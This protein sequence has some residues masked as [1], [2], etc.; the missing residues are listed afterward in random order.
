MDLNTT[1][2]GLAL[3]SPLIGSASPLWDDLALAREAEAA[4]LS[5]LVLRSWFTD[6]TGG[7]GQ[8]AAA[9]DAYLGHLRAAKRALGVPV[10][11]S[12]N[13]TAPDDWT[14]PAKRM[15]DAGAD[16]IE[17]N[18][19]YIPV[20]LDLA[21]QRIE[22]EHTEVVAA[23]KRA[24]SIPIAVKMSPFFT[25]VCN[26]AK[27]FVEAGANG[28]VLF[29]RFFQPDVELET[30]RAVSHTLLSTEYDLRLPLRWIGLLHGRVPTDFAAT[31]GVRT[32]QDAVKLLA[33]GAQAVMLCSAIIDGG[34][35]SV[36]QIHEEVLAWMEA[37][38]FASLADLR[39]RM[40]AASLDDPAAF[41]RA[42]YVDTL[43]QR[44]PRPRGRDERRGTP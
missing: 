42:H 11:A 37:C 10:I 33:V 44:L 15:E 9:F 8:D 35:E 1:Y 32:G 7:G 22:D 25:N 30:M 3:R 12:L 24:V 2:L 4:G 26:M 14:E 16:A 43:R 41:E 13:G 17:L 38:E 23:V 27:R 36:R 29:N 34:V 6:S 40:S 5:A 28:L 39:G 21:A 19:Y 31:G 18:V 20:D